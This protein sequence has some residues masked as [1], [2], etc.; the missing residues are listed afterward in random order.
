PDTP[1]TAF[2]SSPGDGAVLE[3]R[4][5]NLEA[6]GSDADGETISFRFQIASESAFANVIGTSDWAV[7]DLANAKGLGPTKDF[8][9][10]DTWTLKDGT[11]YWWRV[12][13]QDPFG[14]ISAWSG[15]YTFTVELN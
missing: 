2:P 15:A 14:A 11:K 4:R 9:P 3:T 10:P 13:S 8:S 1:P 7:Q 6:R 12:Q 5:P